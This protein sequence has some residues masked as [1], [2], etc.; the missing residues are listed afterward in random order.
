M[1]KFL[2]AA[3]T[4]LLGSALAA[5]ASATSPWFDLDLSSGETVDKAG[6]TNPIAVGGVTLYCR[7]KFGQLNFQ[8]GTDS[9]PNDSEPG[10]CG[11]L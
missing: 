11:Q 3:A 6:N 8:I 4:I 2:S 10:G 5:T 9:D 1:K 7:G